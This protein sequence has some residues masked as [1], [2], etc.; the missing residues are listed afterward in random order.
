MPTLYHETSIAFTA[1]AETEVTDNGMSGP[2]YQQ[3]TEI[4][5]CSIDIDSVEM[6]GR[7]WSR[8]QLVDTFGQKGADALVELLRAEA[9][10]A[11]WD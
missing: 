10:E 6:F 1:T 5:L 9:G 2:H 4:D 11:D 7:E 3:W 8:A